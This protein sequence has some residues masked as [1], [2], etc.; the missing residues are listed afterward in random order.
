MSRST[1]QREALR[2]DR[3]VVDDQRR[4]DGHER[5]GDE[6]GGR[7]AE[8][9]DQAFDEHHHDHADD[10]VGEPGNHDR[11]AE[12]PEDRAQQHRKR[13]RTERSGVRCQ[14]GKDVGDAVSSSDVLG[15][16]QV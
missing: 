16:H 13:R 3:D 8:P 11:L 14:L 15:D 2:E 4:V 6:P 10:D 7:A 9:R 5:G 12:D 1:Q